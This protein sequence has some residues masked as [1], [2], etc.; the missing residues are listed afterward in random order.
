MQ[1]SAE[2][3]L[4][5]LGV[6]FSTAAG[7]LTALHEVSLRVGAGEFAAIVGPSGCGKSTLLRA[8]GGLLA[9]TA[10]SITVGGAGPE[11]A[12]QR[13]IASFVFQQ[14]VLLPW[15]TAQQNI[16]LPLRMFGVPRGRR[17]DTA[18]SYLDLVGLSRFAGAYPWQLSGG[19]QQRV[20]L[21]RAL[22][23][24]PAVLLMDEPFGALDE[25]TRERL[26]GELLR[27][28]G[29]RRTTVLFVTHSLLEAAY[30]ADRVLMFSAQPGRL[31]ADVPM[32]F[33]RPRPPELLEQTAFLQCVADLRR[34]LHGSYADAQTREVSQ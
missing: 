9:P 27:I 18:R 15:Y 4:D 12:R 2:I 28:W 22:A 11:Q 16:E 33:A 23:T 14:P 29:Q 6:V 26:N 34:R 20:A 32:S 13:R 31:V 19:M 3:V 21:A 24:E 17:R 25:I 7:P 5:H 30:L 1:P 10:G 8:V